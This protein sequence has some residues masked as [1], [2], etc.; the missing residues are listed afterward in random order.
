MT[1]EIQKKGRKFSRK[2]NT[3]FPH[4]NRLSLE[5]NL[6]RNFCHNLS[7][8]REQVLYPKNQFRLIFLQ[9]RG[10]VSR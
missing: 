9:I 1:V 7:I 2:L 8:F 3:V 4:G 5:R 6:G 10:G